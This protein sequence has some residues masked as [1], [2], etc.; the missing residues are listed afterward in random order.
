MSKWILKLLGWQIQGQPSTTKYVMILAPHTSNWDFIIGILARNAVDPSIKYMGKSQL[1]KAPWGW[2]FRALGGIPVY[3]DSHN[4]MVQ[5]IAERFN[6]QSDFKV[7][8]APEGTRSP[9][10]KWKMGF[11]H[12]A[13]QAQVPILAVGLDYQ[14][15]TISIKTEQHTSDDMAADCQQLLAFYQGI[16][17]KYPKALPK[18]LT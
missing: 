17:G 9:V 6:R 18:S 13:K 4:N 3:R 2:L 15:K 14:N 7:V 12:I 1:F 16:A 10:T 8:M 5:Q 11:Y